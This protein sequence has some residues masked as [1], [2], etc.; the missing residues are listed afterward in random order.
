M[1]TQKL[2]LF[3]LSTIKQNPRY[4]PEKHCISGLGPVPL[5]NHSALGWPGVLAVLRVRGE[6]RRAQAVP[7]HRGRTAEGVRRGLRMVGDRVQC[8]DQLSPG[9]NY[10]C[11][12]I[13]TISLFVVMYINLAQNAL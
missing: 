2:N 6:L 10:F 7:A 11:L 13:S 8:R 12:P 4:S 9:L 5:L 3:I 1:K